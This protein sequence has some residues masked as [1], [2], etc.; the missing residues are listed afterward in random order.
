MN[1]IKCLVLVSRPEKLTDFAHRFS[2]SLFGSEFLRLH[3]CFIIKQLGLILHWAEFDVF[4]P[5]SSF[6][7]NSKEILSTS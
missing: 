1:K 6:Y 3:S 5:N 2:T 7:Y 4:K